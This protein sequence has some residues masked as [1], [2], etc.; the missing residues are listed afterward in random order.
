M[1]TITVYQTEENYTG[2]LSKGHAEYAEEGS[3]I[4]CAGVSALTVNTINSI[5]A[6]TEDDFSVEQDDGYIR[7]QLKGKA[8]T[9]SYLFMKSLVLGLETIRDNYGNE[10]I[11][12][13]F[14]EV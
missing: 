5:E 13:I 10:Y 2:F 4:I 8:S 1:I 6:F 3:D 7:F 14:K 9:A 12:L 11:E